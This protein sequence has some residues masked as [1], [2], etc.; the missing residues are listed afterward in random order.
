LNTCLPPSIMPLAKAYA[1]AVEDLVAEMTEITAG[2]KG[3]RKLCDIFMY[4]PDRQALPDYFKAVRRPRCIQSVRDNLE[5]GYY[6]SAQAAYDDLLLIFSN[7]LIYN[8]DGSQIA[9]DARQLKVR[10]AC[11][12]SPSMCNTSSES[13]LTRP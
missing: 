4:L 6:S 12:C 2:N 7:A 1:K 11:Y 10:R 8:E 13:L 5:K 9:Q 3:K